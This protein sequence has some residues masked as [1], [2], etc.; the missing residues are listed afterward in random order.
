MIG[1]IIAALFLTVWDMYGAAFKDVLPATHQ[2][3]LP[4]GGG[5]GGKG[6]GGG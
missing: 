4:G 3:G 1:P 6:G 2:A 5:G